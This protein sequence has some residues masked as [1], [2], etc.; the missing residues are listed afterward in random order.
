MN[1]WLYIGTVTHKRVGE[2]AHRFDYPALFLC[3][4]LSQRHLLSNSLFGYNRFKPMSFYEKDHGNGQ[5][6]EQWIRDILQQA[7]LSHLTTGEVWLQTQPR[8]FG[9]VFN[10]VSFWYCHDSK[11][12][13][14]VV[15][16]EVNNTFGEKHCYLLT[17]E[18]QQVISSHTK[19]Q[20]QKVF[21]VSPFFDV[22][23]EYRFQFLHQQNKRTVAINYWLD[24]SLQLKTLITGDAIELSARHII[25]SLI[26]LGWTTVNV[27]IGIHWQALKLWRK[28]AHFYKKPTPPRME[29]S[30]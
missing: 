29:I 19:L 28:G 1:N 12:Q 4:P 6:A 9:Y 27:V 7:Q 14:R 18:Q 22:K 10:P 21:H 2:L 16:C 23:G 15:L 24:G 13:L 26:K 30:S 17:A 11:Q 5:D 8:V 3:F 20:C 25:G